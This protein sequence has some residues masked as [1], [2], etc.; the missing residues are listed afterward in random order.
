MEDE[1]CSSHGSDVDDM[2]VDDVLDVSFQY[3]E[4]DLSETEINEEDYEEEH[5]ISQ[6]ELNF[7]RMKIVSNDEIYIKMNNKERVTSPYLSKFEKTKILGMRATQIEGGAK[8]L[9]TKD[10]IKDFRHSIKIAELEFKNNLIP[11]IIR[12]Y[13][14]N[15]NYEDWK[16]C[17]FH[18]VV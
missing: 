8:T 6:S 13:L 14:P 1:I 17:D 18:N 12:R 2:D 15:G 10:K 5:S 11:F 7:V 4:D 3:Q 9:L 16:L